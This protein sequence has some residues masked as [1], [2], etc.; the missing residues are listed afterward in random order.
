M[1]RALVIAFAIALATPAHA[2]ERTFPSGS[3]VIPMDLSYQSRGMFQA[4]NVAMAAARP[5]SVVPIPPV[6]APTA[7]RKV[8]AY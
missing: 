3:L 4:V 5:A 2:A 8:S 7:L 1:S 6:F